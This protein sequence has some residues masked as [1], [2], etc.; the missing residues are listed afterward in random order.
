MDY[1]LIRAKTVV[2]RTG[3]GRSTLYARCQAG[4]LPAPVPL[5]RSTPGWV[6]SEIQGWIDDCIEQ[7][8]RIYGPSPFASTEPASFLRLKAVV[9]RTGLSRSTLYALGRDGHFPRQVDLGGGVSAWVKGEVQA[10][11]R[12]RIDLRSQR[13]SAGA[14]RLQS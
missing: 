4:T 6:E 2:E 5:G 12:S 9:A 7:R 8:N 3:L 10:W 11:I 13:S 1:Q 14:E